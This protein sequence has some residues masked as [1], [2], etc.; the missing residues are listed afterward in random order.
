MP[1][2]AIGLVLDG[3]TELSSK[4]VFSWIIALRRRT[5]ERHAVL[6]CAKRVSA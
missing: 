3:S 4:L 6:Y 1:T 5:V 2:E